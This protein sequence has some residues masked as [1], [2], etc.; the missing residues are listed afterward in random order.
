M[1]TP[2]DRKPRDTLTRLRLLVK[3]VS[4]LRASV[5]PNLAKSIQLPMRQGP[6]PSQYRRDSR[7]KGTLFAHNFVLFWLTIKSKVESCLS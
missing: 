6:E 7:L 3:S 2:D 1:S 4:E 5:V